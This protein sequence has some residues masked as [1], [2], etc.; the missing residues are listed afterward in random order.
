M[1]VFCILFIIL[2]LQLGHSYMCNLLAVILHSF[3]EL[4]ICD[5]SAIHVA[6]P[7]STKVCA[8]VDNV[9]VFN[10][11][12]ESVLTTGSHGMSRIYA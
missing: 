1:C 10:R 7:F 3:I 9:V 11:H 6:S 2:M 4:F 5:F 12:S 8:P